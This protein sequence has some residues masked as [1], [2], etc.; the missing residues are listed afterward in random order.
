MKRNQ[1]AP[2][3]PIA[4]CPE[5]TKRLYVVEI[6]VNLIFYY[7]TRWI[8]VYFKDE[9]WKS[10]LVWSTLLRVSQAS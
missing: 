2:V 5:K 6:F 9:M 7:V 8:I 4:P 10:G 1:Y 3:L